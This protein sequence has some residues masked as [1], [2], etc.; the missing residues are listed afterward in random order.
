[1]NSRSKPKIKLQAVID[2]A[3]KLAPKYLDNDGEINMDHLEEI[4]QEWFDIDS[5][6]YEE[7]YR[8]QIIEA[9]EEQGLL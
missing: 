9:L 6:Y 1:M 8:E 5:W 7:S 3:I 2:Y 4:L